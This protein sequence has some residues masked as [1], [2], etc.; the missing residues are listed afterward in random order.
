M[1]L[2][3]ASPV[4]LA[5]LVSGVVL[6]GCVTDQGSLRLATT[7][8]PGVDLGS[9]T[10]ADL[11]AREVVGRDTRI[12]SILGVPFLDGPRLERAV[13][14]AL[15]KADGDV[16]LDMRVRSVDYWLLVGWSTLEVRGRVVSPEP[17]DA[18]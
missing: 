2:R 10:L 4:V 8:P 12:G 18:R 15:A 13:D 14:D 17:G 1:P 3:S 7:R 6:A 9:A 16:M 11:P 5:L